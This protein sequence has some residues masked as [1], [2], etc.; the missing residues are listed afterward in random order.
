MQAAKTMTHLTVQSGEKMPT[1]GFGMW[2]IAK[3]QTA[4]AT[5]QAIKAGYRLIDQACDYGNEKECGEGIK[6]AIDEGLVKRE[7]L[8]VTSKLWNTFHRKE[9]VKAACQKSLKDLGLDYLDLYLIHFPIA[10]KYVDPEVR[11]PPEWI[12]DPSSAEPRMEEDNVSYQE[13]WRAMEELAKEG[14]TKNIGCSNIGTTM[15]RDVLN[16]AEVKPAVLQVEMHPYNT[17][18]KLLRFCDSKGIAVTAFSSFGAGSYVEL[19]MATVQESCLEEQTVKDIAGAHSVSPAQVVLRWAVQR[20]TAVIPK[21]V[22]PERM[23]ENIGIQGFEL[24]EDQMKAIGA[25]NKNRR[26]ND[27]GH[28]TEAAFNTFFPIY[29]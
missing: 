10:L 6:K 21:S 2:K 25:M 12:F 28:F 3:D 9:H 26:F 24:T 22:K 13:T 17:Q 8:W 18:D 29:E 27:P 11:Y 16:Y 15:L 20:G 5:Y 14:L 19:G 7:E 4:E 1:V 23:A